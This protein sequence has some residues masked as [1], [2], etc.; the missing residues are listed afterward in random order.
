LQQLDLSTATTQ[1]VGFFN[2]TDL[3]GI[4]LFVSGSIILVTI[5]VVSYLRDPLRSIP[6]PFLA[7]W[8][9][10]W[11]LY[12]ARQGD[13]HRVMIAQHQKYGPLVRTGPKEL[14]VNDGDAVKVIYGKRSPIRVTKSYSSSLIIT[15]SRWIQVSQKRMVPRLARP[16]TV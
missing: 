12:H 9:P 15:I 6:G 11:M 3:P 13:M 8:S 2:M 1:T 10:L 4:P 14:S 16:T 7:K 5:L